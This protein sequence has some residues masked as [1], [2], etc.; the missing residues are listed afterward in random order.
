MQASDKHKLTAADVAAFG[1]PKLK[2][3]QEVPWSSL[4][5]F[6]PAVARL[7]REQ[8]ARDG[9]LLAAVQALG[10]GGT[11]TQ[12]QLAQA[13]EDGAA[14]ALAKLGAALVDDAPAGS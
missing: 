8:A 12:A 10:G 2:V 9:A 7:R 3:G 6:S 14:R 1:D 11:L 5:R 13:A 4:W